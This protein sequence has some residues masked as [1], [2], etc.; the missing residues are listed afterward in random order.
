MKSSDFKILYCGTDTKEA[1]RHLDNGSCCA[2]IYC[3]KG[4]GV[5]LLNDEKAELYPETCLALELDGGSMGI[6]LSADF[7][8]RFAVCSGDSASAIFQYYLDGSPFR[9]VRAKALAQRESPHP[10]SLQKGTPKAVGLYDIHTVLHKVFGEKTDKIEDTAK[11]SSVAAAIKEYIDQNVDKKV[12]LQ[13]ISDAFFIGKTQIF[14]VFTAKYDTSPIKY[15][16]QKKV[17]VSK[18]MLSKTDLKISEIAEAL[19]FSD[20]K[21]YTK[22]FRNITGMLPSEYRRKHSDRASEDNREL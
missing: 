18:E 22:T 8:G 4:Y 14:R 17:E 13:Q 2:F 1:E 9:A 6:T 15:M 11:P 19:C 12:T 3:D 20:T 21:H 16:L 10:R 5:A 7:C